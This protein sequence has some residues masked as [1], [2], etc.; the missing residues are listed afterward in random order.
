MFAYLG[1][2]LATLHFSEGIFGWSA[3][4]LFLVLNVPP[5]ALTC[6]SL[7]LGA[8]F[9]PR[10]HPVRALKQRRYY[11]FIAELLGLS[12]GGPDR[13]PA[14]QRQL[15]WAGNGTA[16]ATAQDLTRFLLLRTVASLLLLLFVAAPT[17]IKDIF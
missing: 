11:G 5:R 13:T 2:S 14:G 1:L 3:R 6:L 8:L 12:L 9:V 4:G 16:K 10:C 17:F 7:V 15:P